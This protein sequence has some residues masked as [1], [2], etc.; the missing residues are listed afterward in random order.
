MGAIVS[1]PTA[2]SAAGALFYG[3]LGLVRALHAAPLLRLVNN[4]SRRVDGWEN[5]K[6]M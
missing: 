6:N 2:C 1:P 5:L 4:M 3:V